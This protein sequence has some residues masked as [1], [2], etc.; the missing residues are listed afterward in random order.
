MRKTKVR[1]QKGRDKIRKVMGEFKRGKLRS[2]S[3][4]GPRIT[5]RRQALAVALSEARRSEKGKRKRSR[6]RSSARA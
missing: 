4:Q 3:K 1:S 6:R 5:S 2:G